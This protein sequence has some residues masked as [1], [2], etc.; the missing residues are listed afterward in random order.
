MC[1]CRYGR[2]SS[3]YQAFNNNLARRDT[4]RKCPKQQ[5]L[6]ERDDRVV[7]DQSC[8]GLVSK[9]MVATQMQPEE[10]IKS[11]NIHGWR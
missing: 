8:Q 1:S 9:F 3:F 11:E 4:G 5:V 10:M 6:F 7:D 2:T